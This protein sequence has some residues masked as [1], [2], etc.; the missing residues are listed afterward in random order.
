MRV[1]TLHFDGAVGWTADAAGPE[2]PQLVIWFASFGQSQTPEAFEGLKAR[3]PTANIVG[4]STNG[5]IYHADVLDG[6]CVAAAISFDN[7]EVK[8]VCEMMTPGAEAGDLGRA[9]ARKLDQEGL[10]GV[11]V[12]ADA[13][14]ING[15]DLIA[16]LSAA[17]SPEVVIFGGMAGDDGKLGTATLASLNEALRSQC[18]VA[19]GFYGSS[20][21]IDHG[22][23]GGWDVLGPCRQV[24]R[25]AGPMLFELDGQPALEV[26]ERLVG[27]ASTNARLRHPFCFKA[28]LDS[29][30]DIIWE[31]VGIDREQNAIIFIDNI[32]QGSWAQLLRGVD[33]NLVEGAAEAAR[34]AVRTADGG[35]ALSLV[36]SCIGRKWVMGQRVGDEAEA[37]Q[38]EI[39]LPTIGFFSYGEVAPHA[40]TGVCTLH[41]ASVAVTTLSEAA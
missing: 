5:E 37:I 4:C 33:E 17:L 21:R 2:A 38:D 6:A 18:A 23:A 25:S 12:M 15:Q 13:F 26:Y 9:L 1:A 36:V 34:K 31:V 14:G 29:K 7:T 20:V 11:L 8:A 24:T 30:Q 28:E 32:V 10:K 16:G 27:D 41:H 40:N 39:G 19:V 3:F 35:Q 22:V